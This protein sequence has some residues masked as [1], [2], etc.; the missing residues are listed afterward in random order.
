MQ[1]ASELQSRSSESMGN[2]LGEPVF[3][4]RTGEAKENKMTA[5]MVIFLSIKKCGRRD[6]ARFKLSFPR[7]FKSNAPLVIKFL[8]VL[9]NYHKLLKLE[10]AIFGF[11][12]PSMCQNLIF[13]PNFAVR[14]FFIFKRS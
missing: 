3:W 10:I 12:V 14:A 8:L 1:S 4:E 11:C 5:R 6:Y 7:G 2:S 13:S 9:L